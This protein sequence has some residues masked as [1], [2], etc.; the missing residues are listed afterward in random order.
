MYPYVGA[1][2]ANMKK[3]K[4]LKTYRESLAEMKQNIDADAEKIKAF[5]KKEDP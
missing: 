3:S 4:S 1:A 2:I 5:G